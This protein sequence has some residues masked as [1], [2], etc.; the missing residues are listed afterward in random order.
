MTGY[1]RS[2]L[3]GIRSWTD[4]VVKEDLERMR[5]YHTLRREDPGLAPMEYEFRFTDKHGEI[6]HCI[7]NVAMIPG[8]TNSVASILD[9]TGH[10]KAEQEK[11]KLHAQL[12]QA[13]K[14]ESVGILAGG[15][16]HDFN[17]LLTAIL[18]HTDLALMRCA[19]SD[20]VYSDLTA[21]NTSARR[22][23]DL[24]RQLL[25]FARKQIVAPKV[26]DLND[27]IAGII[28]MLNR[29]IGEEITFSWMPGKKLWA[30]KIDPSQV[31]QLL[32]NLCINARDA[33]AGIGKITIETKNT[34]FDEDYCKDHPGLACGEFVML[35]VSDDGSG[36][37]K[38]VLNHLFEP[39][40]TT[41]ELGKGTGL[42]LATVYGIV[43]QNNGYINV[44]SEPGK[45]ST[46][47]IYLPRYAG[48]AIEMKA[49]SKSE[50]PDAKGKTVLLV[51]DAAVILTVSRG[52]LERIGCSVLAAGSPS[53][54]LQQAK[55]YSGKI[56][57]LV[58]DVVM[59]EMNGRELAEKLVKIIPELK[60]LYT[61]GYTS[62]VI[63]HHG[64]L[65]KD[66][67]FLQKP[68]T[69]KDLALKIHEIL[70]RK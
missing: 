42:G 61:S 14:M 63:A 31:D 51:D 17:N 70:N 3:E 55:A 25:A 69:V 19:K 57:L 33:I 27:T 1:E 39:F 44:Y 38:D 11:E 24:V 58:T 28:K 37:D 56:D 12:M 10:K 23:A 65:D 2:E 4:F 46:F 41:K 21:I 43:K 49:E 15:V 22:S 40:F 66:V 50:I 8:T 13:Q 9:I 48:E 7:L 6:H 68:Y 34:E 32:A 18:G 52:M 30:V 20:P 54:A 62:D 36:M 35:S 16:A 53:D 47:T 5:K 60:C 26:L 29:L 64:V 59:P 67:D 45:G